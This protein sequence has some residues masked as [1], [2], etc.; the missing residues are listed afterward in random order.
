MPSSS[1]CDEKVFKSV[2]FDNAQ[3][4]KEYMYYRCG[5]Q[6]Q[7]EDY[8]QDAFSKLWENCAKV[9]FEKARSFLFKIA[10][11]FFL[12]QVKRKKVDLKFKKRLDQK[13]ETENPEFIYQKKEFHEL[14]ERT[15]SSLPEDQRT[16][17]LLNRIEKKKYREIAEMLDISVKTVEK[18]M[19]LA[20][21]QLRKVHPKV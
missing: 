12:N 3:S 10:N 11:N 19:H 15:I 9:S 17:F 13:V 14:L 5:N 4:L 6:E 7:A 8:M 20:L 21:L 1:I 18:K 16:I 2:F